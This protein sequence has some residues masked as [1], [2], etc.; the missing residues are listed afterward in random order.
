MYD[1]RQLELIHSDRRLVRAASRVLGP[2]GTQ[3]AVQDAFVRALEADDALQ[4][5]AA[6]ASGRAL[7]RLRQ[8]G[9]G[10]APGWRAAVRAAAGCAASRARLGDRA[11]VTAA[12]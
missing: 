1:E 9:P 4:L 5:N 11:A 6:Q 8:V 2:V 7:A 12:S 10:D 3:G